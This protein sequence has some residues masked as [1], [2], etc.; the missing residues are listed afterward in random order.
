MNTYGGGRREGK[1][2]SKEEEGKSIC[3]D[4]RVTPNGA[5]LHMAR[6]DPDQLPRRPTTR[7]AE[8]G[9]RLTG[10]ES[11]TTHINFMKLI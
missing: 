3:L 6:P 1:K 4:P 8:P 9:S 2:E 10:Q 7:T 11:S 5:A